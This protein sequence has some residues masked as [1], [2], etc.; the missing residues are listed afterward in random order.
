MSTGRIV[1][2]NQYQSSSK[3]FL[4]VVKP[5]PSRRFLW[6]CDQAAIGPKVKLFM[7]RA[8]VEPFTLIINLP[9]AEHESWSWKEFARGFVAKWITDDLTLP[10]FQSG[11]K[12]VK[13]AIATDGG[14][15]SLAKLFLLEKSSDEARWWGKTRKSP[16]NCEWIINKPSERREKTAKTPKKLFFI[17]TE[18]KFF[19]HKNRLRCGAKLQISSQINLA[20]LYSFRCA[21]I[22]FPRKKICFLEVI[23][24][25]WANFLIRCE[26]PDRRKCLVRGSASCSP[27]MDVFAV[28]VILKL[29]HV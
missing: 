10:T 9:A 13:R 6:Y 4:L 3:E 16:D 21:M 12:G 11:L 29:L 22:N 28:I 2:V 23:Y 18:N 15:M 19:H 26:K 7:T 24:P 1:A 14:I 5:I 25:L 17:F 27:S 20:L 8:L